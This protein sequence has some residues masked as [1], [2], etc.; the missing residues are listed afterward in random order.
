M[1]SERIKNLD[2]QDNYRINLQLISNSTDLELIVRL[3]DST[4]DK[5]IQNFK[6]HLLVLSKFVKDEDSKRRLAKSNSQ[7]IQELIG[8]SLAERSNTEL[9]LDWSLKNRLIT[10]IDKNNLFI[11]E[12]A[13]TQITHQFKADLI[14]ENLFLINQLQALKST[15]AIANQ[16]DKKLLDRIKGEKS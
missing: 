10:N 7:L 14:K 6:Q 13:N 1:D 9:K 3:N 16:N 8:L 2:D 5:L 15:N 11:N 4:C 12:I